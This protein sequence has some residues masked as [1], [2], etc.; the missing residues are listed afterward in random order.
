MAFFQ[1]SLGNPV[2]ESE[3]FQISAKQEDMMAWQVAVPLAG[4]YANHS[5][6]TPDR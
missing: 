3:T 5:H 4:P 6:L 1:Y 2:P